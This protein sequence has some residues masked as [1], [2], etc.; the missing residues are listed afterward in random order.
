MFLKGAIESVEEGKMHLCKEVWRGLD[1]KEVFAV[2]C[3][4]RSGGR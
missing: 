2:L 1:A 3:C 4:V